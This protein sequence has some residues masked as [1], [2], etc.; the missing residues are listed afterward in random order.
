MPLTDETIER[1]VRRYRREYDCYEKLC[2]CVA[3]KCERDIIRANTLR[4][5]VSARAKS[6]VKLRGKLQKKYKAEVDL[7]TVEDALGRITDLAGVRISTYLE[8]DRDRVVE[9]IKKLFDGPNSGEVHVD[10]KDQAGHFYRA[11]HCQ[12]TLKQDDLVEPFENLEGLTCEIQVCSLLAHVW[13]ELEHDLVYKPTSGEISDRETDSLKVLGNLTLSGDVVIKQL[14]EANADRI[15]R[16]QND[17]T[18]FQDVYDFVGRM[19][20]AFPDR[21]EFGTHAGQLFED[22][23]ALGFDTPSKVKTQ[24]LTTEHAARSTE[25]LRQMEEYLQQHHD[26]AVEVEPQSSD[27]LLMLVLDSHCDQVLREHPMGRGRGRPPRIASFATR[28]KQMKEQQLSVG[29]D[30]GAVTVNPDAANNA[31]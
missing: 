21:P 3:A 6:P 27:A 28:F 8:V 26:D 15:K 7:N 31:T 19:R 20:A 4:A 29:H 16:E 10:K 5:A 22:L 30:A 13:N 23:A 25:L 17:A 18:P 12:V 14:F 11:T 24:F 2:R 9:E 1:A